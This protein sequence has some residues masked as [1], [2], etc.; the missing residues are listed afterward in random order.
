MQRR[1]AA[2]KAIPPAQGRVAA[3]SKLRFAAIGTTARSGKAIYSVSI[4]GA[5]GAPVAGPASG[6]GG[7]SL[8]LRKKVEATRS[9]ASK[10]VTPSPTSTTSP[11]PSESGTWSCGTFPPK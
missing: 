1:S 4:P 6:R 3:S 11:A 9:P 7:P 10:R 2:D 8:Q 5:G